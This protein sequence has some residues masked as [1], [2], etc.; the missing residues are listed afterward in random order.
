MSVH[1]SERVV[2]Q[3]MEMYASSLLGRHGVSPL[4]AS[5]HAP[6]KVIFGRDQPFDWDWEIVAGRVTSNEVHDLPDVSPEIWKIVSGNLKISFACIESHIDRPW[7]FS[8]LSAR[9]D[10]GQAFIDKTV[11]CGWD[12]D[13]LER[14]NFDVP[15]AR[16]SVSTACQKHVPLTDDL[17]SVTANMDLNWDFVALSMHPKLTADILCATSTKPWD[18]GNLHGVCG[19]RAHHVRETIDKPWDFGRLSRLHGIVDVAVE[20]PEKA[21]NFSMLTMYASLSQM[22][23]N[24][25]FPWHRNYTFYRPPS[26][27]HNRRL[28]DA[29][30]TIQCAVRRWLARRLRASMTIQRS[31]FRAKY[32]PSHRVCR[33]RLLQEFEDLQPAPK[34]RTRM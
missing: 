18:W 14:R 7:N 19:L 28:S 31:F 1:A 20:H 23:H 30:V 24:P 21:W 10:L 12:W 33:K 22:Y 8:V 3:D 13:L 15:A 17:S 29:A 25:A 32:D 11:A 4:Y 2:L 16:A 9:P 34:R 6:L 26:F 5:R 27:E